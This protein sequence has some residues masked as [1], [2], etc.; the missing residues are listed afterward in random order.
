VIRRRGRTCRETRW[1]R[2]PLAM[3]LQP[4]RLLLLMRRPSDGGEGIDAHALRGGAR[5]GGVVSPREVGVA[6][7]RRWGGVQP[8]RSRRLS[9]SSHSMPGSLSPM[10][11]NTARSAAARQPIPDCRPPVLPG[12]PQRAR[13]GPRAAA[14]PS[15]GAARYSARYLS[16]ASPDRS[17]L[18][19][20]WFSRATPAGFG[21]RGEGFLGCLVRRVLTDQHRQVFRHAAAPQS[22]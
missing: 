11:A 13:R 14:A 4:C 1:R 19:S 8:S 16:G 5:P 18:T 15:A 6:G 7:L 17:V 2:R 21:Q 22:G 20:K 10:V 3:L 9:S 12:G